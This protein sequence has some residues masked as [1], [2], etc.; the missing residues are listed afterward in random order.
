MDKNMLN[1]NIEVNK[2]PIS[3]RDMLE[4]N[5]D[6]V[7]EKRRL[8][9]QMRQKAMDAAQEESFDQMKLKDMLFKPTEIPDN[10]TINKFGEIER[11]GKTR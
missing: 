9:E 5:I 3:K 4:P 1:T 6:V 10:Y 2:S 8:L 11:P 7:G